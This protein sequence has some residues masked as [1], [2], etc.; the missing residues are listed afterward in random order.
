[1]KTW[2][3]KDLRNIFFAYGVTFVLCS[4]FTLMLMKMDVTKFQMI[5]TFGTSTP[6][7]ECIFAP[8]VE[9]FLFRWIWIAAAIYFLG[10]RFKKIMWPFA[11]FL[12]IVFGVAHFGYFSIF[13]QGV[14]GMGLCYLYYKNRYGY[15]SAVIC[16]SLWN[17]MLGVILPAII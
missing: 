13:I 3:F 12:S 14:L 5:Q 11:A 10:K 4:F 1:M 17:L 15:L 8:I 9:E 7:Y 2:W 6:V 16:H